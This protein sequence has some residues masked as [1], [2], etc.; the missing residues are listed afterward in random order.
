VLLGRDREMAAIERLLEEARDSR[1]GALVLRG[2]PG[3]GKSALLEHAVERAAGMRVLTA[4]GVEAESELPFAGL[5]QLLW[6][7]LDRVDGLPPVQRHA[8]RAAF[9]L[10]TDGVADRFV[11]SVAVL[12]LLTAVADDEPLACVV[13]D[14]HWLDRAS[15]DTLVFAVRRLHADPIAVLAA[16]REVEGRR[17]ATA[18]MG[19]LVV[20]GLPDAAAAALL[21]S[22]LP[23]ALRHQLV[24]V[25]H[26]NPLALLE[27]PRGLTEE[28][29]SGRAPL[30]HDVPLSAEIEDA[31]LARVRPLPEDTQRLLAL[32][33]ADDSQELGTVLAAAA[34]LGIP[35][36]ALDAA[37]RAGLLDT[38]GERVR[39]RHPLVRSAV[40]RAATSG[41]RR[42]AHTALAATLVAERDADRHAWHRAAA[43]V[44]PDEEAAAELERTAERARA[45]GGHAAAAR[46]LERAAELGATRRGARL[47][48]AAATA[49]LAG[50][51]HHVKALLDRAE[52]LLETP[53]ERG[54]AV[55]VRLEVEILAGS[56]S[57][58]HAAAV[59]SA[60]EVLPLDRR[61]GLRLIGLAGEAAGMGGYPD[62]FLETTRLA[63]GLEPPPDDDLD[64]VAILLLRG[65]QR[66]LTG[67]PQGA[68]PFFLQALDRAEALDEP[69]ALMWTG[70]GAAFVGDRRRSLR[71]LDRS[72]AL[73]R[74]RGALGLLPHALGLRGN[75]AIWDGRL[76]EAGADADEAV[77]L[78][79]D[80]G[81][82]NARAL[83]L[84][85][86]AWL[87]GLRGEEEEC[88]RLVEDVLE[89]ATERG[90][91][92]PA[93]S[94]TW[95]IAQVDVATGRWEEALVRLLALEELRP[96]FGHPLL[97]YMTT[98]DRVEAAVRLGRADVAERSIARFATWSQATA[99]AWTPVVLE[100]CRALAAAPDAA[101]AH[102][103]AA[104]AHLDGARPLDRARVQ[105]HY[106]EHLRRERRRIDARVHL[107]ESIAA[108]ER[109][110]ARPWIERAARELRATGETA[111]RRDISPLAEL[112]PQE[113]QVARLVG[114]GATNKAVAA[115]LFV[116]PKTV[117]Y[118]L[119]K[120]F[121]KLGIAS[122]SE[123]FRLNLAEE[124]IAA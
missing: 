39:F 47:L 28:Q 86:L 20:G 13:D 19:E 60:R 106:G 3:I 11:M 46:A 48:A 1:S 9:G 66:L 98:W 96:G 94:A 83:P 72:I 56:P 74:E 118:H 41:E 38:H 79:E 90:L 107:R 22:E 91:A 81:A 77:R 58:H 35:R 116:S 100:S 69:R 49:L 62:R 109:L 52:P 103:L 123:L 57:R 43:A 104:L 85:T 115:Q 105:L 119:R 44:A 36:S 93:A 16:T 53:L 24:Q 99:P 31:F 5:H 32:A 78:A 37:E 113:L 121:A 59:A 2:E 8:L 54:E 51:V 55:R 84:T 108:F 80:I 33:A 26:G 45:R 42:A 102:F 63:D 82:E 29:R 112:T 68:G 70:G 10:S 114:E 73:A 4:T 97:P 111:R 12:A 21:G 61:A 27:L 67:D 120:V 64:A 95:S 23:G 14:A 17:F 117:E 40:Y 15:A 7:V 65:F 122:R 6:P 34:Q 71:A 76:P 110:G 88:R 30:L 18:G 89:L 124:E 75:L 25:T 87:K 101:E 92:L 50:R